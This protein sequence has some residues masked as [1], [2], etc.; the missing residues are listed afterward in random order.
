MGFF[1]D[2]PVEKKGLFD[3]VPLEK[4]SDPKIGQPEELKWYEKLAAALPD[5]FATA[6][7]R[8]SP[9]GRVA[10]GLA[11]PGAAVVQMAANALPGEWGGDVNAAIRRREEEYQ[12]ARK[13]A[14]SEGF[15]PLRVIGSSIITAPTPGA[16][17]ARGAAGMAKAAGIGGATAAL[18]PVV[19]DGDFWAKKGEQVGTGAVTGA[20]LSPLVGALARTVAPKASM[21]A[22]VELLR[23]EGVNPTAG[24]ALGGWANRLE[25]K[26]TSLPIMGDAISAARRRAVEEFNEAAIDR[27]VK[28][29]GGWVKGAGHEAIAEAGD[30]LDNAYKQALRSVNHVNFDT[31]Q[32]NA[33][34][35][36]LQQMT[37]GLSEPMQK[38]WASVLSENVFR[39]MSPNGSILGADLK[40]VDSSL[41]R[42]ASEY[43]S[44]PDPT[45]RELGDAILQLK[46][47]LK[48]QVARSS[49]EVAAQLKAADRGWAEL[50]R[51]EGAGKRAANAEGIFTP[52][53]YTMAVREGDRSV[54]KR[55]TARGEALGQD[56]AT[57]AQNVLGNKYP[58]SGTT[59]RML[60]GVGGLAAGAVHPAIPAGLVAGAAAYTPPVQN[61]IVKLLTERPEMA[62]DVANYLR[63]LVAPGAWAAGML[64]EDLR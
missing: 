56:L 38:K 45:H 13:A 59:G 48:E 6:N 47:L 43:S 36:Q 32:F 22:D 3:D 4:R 31:P 37:S 40:M 19:A 57:A 53:Q 29:V 27:A 46:A 39:K 54:R 5:S 61:F 26:L 11:D 20:A 21:N 12:A 50:V 58:D 52:A 62:P 10:K 64:S 60:A 15:D 18:D 34:F 23:R 7:V 1:D 2:I 30:V 55:A 51:L 16:V 33:Q 42:V 63:R 41:G 44:S 35:G 9:V 14:G 49:P 25:E 28:P 8:G 17:A 24:Q